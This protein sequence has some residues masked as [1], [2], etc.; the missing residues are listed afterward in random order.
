MK[1]SRT[2]WLGKQA[3]DKAEADHFVPRRVKDFGC[4]QE[5]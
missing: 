2:T 1:D 3:G 4:M 5:D